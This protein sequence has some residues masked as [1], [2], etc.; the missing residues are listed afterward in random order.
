MSTEGTAAWRTNREITWTAERR[1]I[2]YC[3]LDRA[4]GEGVAKGV[5]EAENAR[6]NGV[7]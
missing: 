1:Y 2:D 3:R 7:G 5:Q 6:T 4:I